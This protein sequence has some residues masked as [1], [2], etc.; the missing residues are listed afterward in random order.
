MCSTVAAQNAERERLARTYEQGSDWRS[1]AKIYLELHQETPNNPRY[2]NGVVRCL[3]SLAQYASLLPIVEAQLARSPTTETAIL[4]GITATRAGKEADNYWKQA[5]AIGGNTEGVF[6]SLGAAQAEVAQTEKALASYLAARK[7]SGNV[8]AYALELSTL[9]SAEG[10]YEQAAQEIVTQYAVDGNE[11]LAQGRLAALMITPEGS[12]AIGKVLGE[13]EN[14]DLDIMRLQWWYLTQVGQ[15]EK[16]LKI[17]GQIDK[18]ENLRGRLLLRFAETARQEQQYAIAMQTYR[19]LMSA[20]PSI[21]IA[22]TYGYTQTLDQQF[23][24]SPSLNR[25]T[26]II[27][28]DQYQEIATKYASHP[29]SANALLRIAQIDVELGRPDEARETLTRLSNTWPGTS[30]A[31][32]GSLLLASIYYAQGSRTMA[33]ELLHNV[34]RT[35]TEYAES[36]R[37]MLADYLL[38]AGNLAEAQSVYLQ[39]SANTS[40]SATNDALERLGLLMYKQDDSTGVLAM[41]DALRLSALHQST[42]AAQAFVHAAE[43]ATEPTIQDKAHLEAAA[44]FVNEADSVAAAKQLDFIFSRIPESSVG[45]RALALMAG[46]QE[47][48]GNTQGAVATLTTLLVQY[49]HSILAPATRE[50]IRRLRGDA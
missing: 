1:A 35:Q 12:L 5:V 4:A 9:Y 33:E 18:T 46:L 23:L 22:A 47:K 28:R 13:V 29:L 20:E 6:A 49:P 10:K 2:F 43:V 19:S 37:L 27:V 30:A 26:G 7:L 39:I 40:S 31:L 48:A 45:D 50:R 34:E 42:K 3:T 8:R 41:I 24:S 14:T 16:A 15:W 11:Q 44:I 25:D 38:Y 32:Q 36:A 21:A 17:V